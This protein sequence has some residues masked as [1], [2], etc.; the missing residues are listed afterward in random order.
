MRTSRASRWTTRLGPLMA[1]VA[2]ILAFAVSPAAAA[3]TQFRLNGDVHVAA[4]QTVDSAVTLNGDITIEGVVTNSAFTA[5]GDIHVLPG[6]RVDGDAVSLTGRVLVDAEG[7][8]AGDTVEFGKGGI[9]VTG[10]DGGAV[11]ARNVGVD[12]GSGV[13]W[14]FFVLGAMGLGLLLVL[15]AGGSLKSVGRELTAR[16]GR[17][18]LVGLLSIIGVPVLFV[19][20]LISVVGIPV[21][22]MLIPLVP[23]VGMFGIYAI[24]LLAGQR[25]LETIGRGSAGE[26]WAMLAGVALLGVATLIPVLG[27]LLWVIAGFFGFGATVTRVWEHY[28]DRRALRSAGRQAPPEPPWPDGGAAAA[29]PVYPTA[30]QAPPTPEV[31]QAPLPAEPPQP[32]EAPQAPPAAEAPEQPPAASEPEP[33]ASAPTAPGADEAPPAADHGPRFHI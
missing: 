23:L 33:P 21:A 30:P 2:L 18:A 32:A 15:I 29:P 12:A 19:I 20:L 1:A 25:L 8:V 9:N 14:F 11:V 22:L 17:S 6:G 7:S 27:V 24:A 5:N 4:D 31:T 26:V 13:G 3:P 16:T 28:Q 10:S